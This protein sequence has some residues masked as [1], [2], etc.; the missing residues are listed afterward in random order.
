MPEQGIAVDAL[1]I[2]LL[3]CLVAGKRA[4]PASVMFKSLAPAARS[5]FIYRILFA[6]GPGHSLNTI[7]PGGQ[8]A[9]RCKYRNGTARSSLCQVRVAGSYVEE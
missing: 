9:G 6:S 1:P 2:G 4:Q 8:H 3:T 7:Y 5:S